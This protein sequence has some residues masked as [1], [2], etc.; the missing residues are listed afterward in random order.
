MGTGAVVGA[1]SVVTRNVAAYSVVGGIPAK[2]LRARFSSAIAEKLLLSQYWEYPFA[3]LKAL[4]CANV[5]EFLDAFA[6]SEVL[7]YQFE[8]LEFS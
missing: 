2:P 3:L 6:L 1:N 8:T 5:F 4:P 7:P